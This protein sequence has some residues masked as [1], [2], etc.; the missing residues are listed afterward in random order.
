MIIP[1]QLGISDDGMELH[2]A[3]YLRDKDIKV[4]P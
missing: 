2:R 1:Y 3:K 4:V